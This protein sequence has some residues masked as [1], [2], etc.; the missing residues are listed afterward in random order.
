M[1]TAGGTETRA[2]THLLNES[3]TQQAATLAPQRR[4]NSHDVGAAEQPAGSA[5]FKSSGELEIDWRRDWGDAERSCTPSHRMRAGLLDFGWMRPLPRRCG[6]RGP[7]GQLW[8]AD[9]KI[10]QPA[11]RLGSDPRCNSQRATKHGAPLLPVLVVA[12]DTALPPMNAAIYAS[13]V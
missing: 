7:Q 1:T 2:N 12:V 11:R 6:A 5:L 9:C 8:R 13:S 4:T 3:Y 10:W